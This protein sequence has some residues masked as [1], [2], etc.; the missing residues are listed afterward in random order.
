MWLWFLLQGSRSVVGINSKYSDIKDELDRSCRAFEKMYTLQFLR[1]HGNDIHP[2][3][4]LPQSLKY[5]PRDI[6]LLHWECFPMTCLPSNFDP[7]FLIELN[8]SYSQ[9]ENLWEGF[10][11][12]IYF[13]TTSYINFSFLR[14]YNLFSLCTLCLIW[15]EKVI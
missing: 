5:L 3:S 13:S 14:S 4:Y 12:S 2:R 15:K 10:Y 9:L 1:L 7:R 6:K 11:V 8:M